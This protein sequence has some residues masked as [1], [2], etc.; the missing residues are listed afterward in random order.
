MNKRLGRALLFAFIIVWAIGVGLG[1]KNLT[2]YQV[3]AGTS[4]EPPKL[5]PEGTSIPRTKGQSTLV[6]L[7]HPHCPCTRATL[8]ELAILMA[9]NQGKVSAYVLFYK[10][11]NFPDNWEQTDL[12]H[13]AAEIP[14]VTV[15]A[16]SDGVEAKRFG[17]ATSGQALLYGPEGDLQF[18]GGITAS[19]GH[20]GDNA[21]RDAITDLLQNGKSDAKSTLVYGCSLNGKNQ[22]IADE[23]ACHATGR[24]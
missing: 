22:N 13:S 19:R 5:W 4:A 18:T 10:P 2:N 11:S 8:G 24:K 15:M 23:G 9:R 12:W 16:D 14:G 1:L 20:S 7:A 17:S 21:G 6:L 3:S